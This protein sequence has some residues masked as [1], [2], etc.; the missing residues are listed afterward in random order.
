M[1][2]CHYRTVLVSG[3]VRTELVCVCVGGGGRDLVQPAAKHG[4]CYVI[5]VLLVLVV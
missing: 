2:G 3:V 1:E 5:C 4:N